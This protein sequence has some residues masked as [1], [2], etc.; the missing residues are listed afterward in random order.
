MCPDPNPVKAIFLAALQGYAPD[1]WPAYLDAACGG[2]AD[3]RRR[4]ELLLQAHLEAGGTL[5]GP[6]PDPT[7]PGDGPRREL[8]RV[9]LPPLHPADPAPPAGGPR[10]EGSGGAFGA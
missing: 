3:L 5:D 10:R 9:P 6:G 4:A 8:D 2:D 7:P 1:Q